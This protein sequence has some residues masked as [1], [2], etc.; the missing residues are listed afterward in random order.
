MRILVTGGAGFIGSHI[1]D[2]LLERGHIVYVCDDL[3]SGKME[4]VNP[5]AHFERCDI[6]DPVQFLSLCGQVH[7]ETVCH[8]AAQPSLLRSERA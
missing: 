4:N 8:Q 3:S 7:F 6:A 2:A 1:V 5:S